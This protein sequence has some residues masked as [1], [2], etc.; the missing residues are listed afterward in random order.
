MEIAKELYD[1]GDD[2]DESPSYMVIYETLH[3]ICEMQ[4]NIVDNGDDLSVLSSTLGALPR[5]T[6]VGLCFNKPLKV[7]DPLL[8][9]QT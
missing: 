1:G 4:R 5:L 7:E 6:E 3:D 9:L 2:A 8:S